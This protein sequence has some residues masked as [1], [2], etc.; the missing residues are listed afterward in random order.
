MF[1][2]YHKWLGIPEDQ[3]PPTFYQLLGIDPEE[4]D[5]EVIRESGIRQTSYLRTYQTG[6]QAAECTRLLNEVAQA[7]ATLLNPDR[8]RQYDARLHE[9]AGER[10]PP[11]AP[12]ADAAWD[13]ESRTAESAVGVPADVFCLETDLDFR[14]GGNSGARA[15]SRRKPLLPIVI[16]ACYAALLLLAGLMAFWMSLK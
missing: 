9:P 4:T 8:R 11:T 5:E 1:N 2:T 12:A 10:Q 15:T 6:P 14:L 3:Q 7:E 13:D 16:A